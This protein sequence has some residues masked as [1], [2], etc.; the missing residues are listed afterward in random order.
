MKYTTPNILGL[1]ISLFATIVI[2]ILSLL[3]I[4][5]NSQ[6]TF[7]ILIVVSIVNFLILY[8]V[9]HK[10][11]KYFVTHKI[12]PI[13]KAIYNSGYSYEENKNDINNEYSINNIDNNIIKTKDI[14][15]NDV[16]DHLIQLEKYRKEFLGNVSHELKTPIFNIQGYILT[17]LDGGIEDTEISKLYLQRTDK[18][19]NRMISIVEDLESISR[20]ES[21]ELSLEYENF[22]IYN[23][24]KD[25]FENLEIKAKGKNIK[26]SFVNNIEKTIIV[27]ADKRR[28]FQ[29]INNLV[30]NSI[31]YGKEN[32]QTIIDF[33]D[34]ENV[35]LVDISD[36]GI[37]IDEKFIPRLFERF[38]RIDKSRSREQGGTGLGLAIV[39]HIIEA[40][41]QS[42]KV[43]STPGERTT[44]AFTL[45]KSK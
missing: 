20:L 19:V 37:G 36:N 5:I 13:Y 35:V 3:T 31:K 21:G 12:K 45:L 43:T 44:F 10:V 23:L 30:D 4:Y 42:I 7:Y 40:H 38:F 2:I 6:Y 39:K 14:I 28:I 26:L 33:F 27:Y 11:L 17:L 18:N 16:I 29:L 1:I 8:F 22:N 34:M 32:G 15:N 41:K 24:I 25:V 9:I